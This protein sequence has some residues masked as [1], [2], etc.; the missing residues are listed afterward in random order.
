MRDEI[1]H[2]SGQIKVWAGFPGF[3]RLLCFSRV[4]FFVISPAHNPYSFHHLQAFIQLILN[5][6]KNFLPL[7]CCPV[8]LWNCRSGPLP[9]FN[10][11]NFLNLS[12]NS[13]F[14]TF[15]T[16]VLFWISVNIFIW[17]LYLSALVSLKRLTFESDQILLSFYSKRDHKYEYMII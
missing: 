5:I 8:F 13:W 9:W 3:T 4:W 17:F 7:N 10:T 12:F 2:V 15:S 6:V 11:T 16:L 14:I 1:Y